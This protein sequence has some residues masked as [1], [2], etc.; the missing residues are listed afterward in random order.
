VPGFF[1]CSVVL[2]LSGL[3][4]QYYHTKL[5]DLCEVIQQLQEQ[6]AQDSGGEGATVGWEWEDV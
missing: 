2:L 1:P 3:L 6:Q 4:Q 5:H